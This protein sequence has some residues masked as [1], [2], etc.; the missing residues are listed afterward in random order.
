MG[1]MQ[2]AIGIGFGVFSSIVAWLVLTR[3]LSPKVQ[4]APTIQRLD[5]PDGVKYRYLI[6]NVRWWRRAIDVSVR[7]RFMIPGLDVK[8][9]SAVVTF[10]VPVDDEWIPWLTPS[11]RYRKKRLPKHRYFPQSP[12]LFLDQV[13][14]RVRGMLPKD[15]TGDLESILAASP[16]ARSRLVVIAHDSYTGSRSMAMQE[17]RVGDIEQTA[18]MLRNYEVGAFRK[19]GRK[20]SS[21]LTQVVTASDAAPI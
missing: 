7:A 4:I 10:V 8:D 13:P 17:F 6:R 2:T 14:E 21:P 18:E 5:S 19:R 1:S 12:V 9:P 15:W 11:W 3:M 16:R 20:P